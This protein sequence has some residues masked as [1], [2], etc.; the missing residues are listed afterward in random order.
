MSNKSSIFSQKILSWHDQYGR[1]DLPWQQQHPYVVWVSEVMLQQTQVAT[2]MG[3]FER[4]MQQFP[5]VERLA[6]AEWQ[7]VAHLW[8]GLGY[9]A[10]ARNLHKAAKTVVAA[11]EFPNT[12]AGWQALSG[13]GQS[14]AGAIMAMGQGQY[15]VI[16]DGNVKRVLTRYFAIEA[17]ISKTATQKQLWQLA[18]QLTP[19]ERSGQYAQAMMDLGA[20]LC[21]RRQPK[22]DSCPVK[23]HCKASQLGSPTRFPIKA[24]KT[25]LPHRYSQVLIIVNPNNEWLWL[26]RPQTGIWGGLWCLPVVDVDNMGTNPS[27]QQ[28][29]VEQQLKQ[30]VTSHEKLNKTTIK[31]IKHTLTHFHW[32]LQPYRVVISQSCY[33]QIRQLLA[34]QAQVY[35]WL[36]LAQAHKTL[37][38]PKAMLKIL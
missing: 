18:D 35:Q 7:A 9:Y 19:N 1:H 15:G 14:T 24:K 5:T 33:Q 6:Q 32:H 25:K 11:G 37:A 34:T 23:T 12:L 20:T 3:Y 38:L 31:P 30:L 2:V 26:Q 22:C 13:I 21:T 8:A 29:P 36:T 4:F 27:Q 17:D 16:L 28:Q 10:R